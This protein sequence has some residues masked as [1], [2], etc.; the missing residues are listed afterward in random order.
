MTKFIEITN[1]DIYNK[2]EH[3]IK[4]N[5]REHKEI[6]A[7]QQ[8]T[9]GKVQLNKWIATTALSVSLIAIGFLVNHLI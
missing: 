4:T 1:K 7:H 6:I 3:L 2:I 5:G 8:K 9:N